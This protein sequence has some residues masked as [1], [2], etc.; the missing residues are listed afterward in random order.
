MK[1]IILPEIED[2]KHFL[3]AG[4]NKSLNDES[5]KIRE[6]ILT[7]MPYIDE[8][9]YSDSTYGVHWSNIK[10]KF[11]QVLNSLC[12][13]T[14]ANVSIKQMGGMKHNYD[15]LISFYSDVERKSIIKNVKLEF[16][17]NNTNVSDLVQF[18]ELYDK[19]C[20]DK[21]NICNMSYAE[22]YYDNYL[23][24][25]ISCDSELENCSIPDRETYLKNVYDIK[26]K[27]AFFKL[28]HDNKGRN[29][30]DKKHI[31]N[32]SICKYIEKYHNEFNFDKIVEKIKLSQTSKV[33]LL[34]D[35][36][37]FHIQTLDV[38]NLSITNIK[39]VEKLYLDL[40]TE[41]FEYNIR[42]RL[43]WGNSNGLANPRWKFSFINK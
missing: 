2:I 34:W 3:G 24:Q 27:H 22:F 33:F 39:K 17:H 29:I 38:S 16:K 37:N 41:N 1:P 11:T 32:I 19:D 36:E 8:D 43:N 25:Y 14:Y 31:A 10:Q 35:C 5:N 7:C 18:L 6:H 20:K 30:S 21:F 28:L 42:V 9:Y 26:Y 40:E 15:L 12:E 4:I 13:E 23:T